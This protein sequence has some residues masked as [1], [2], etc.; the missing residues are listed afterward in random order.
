MDQPHRLAQSMAPGPG[1]GLAMDQPC[2]PAKS[3][4]LGWVFQLGRSLQIQIFGSIWAA[5]AL[6]VVAPRDTT[7]TKK[8][9]EP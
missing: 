4:A 6:I 3:G 8:C 2:A 7:T 9:P 1:M 5:A